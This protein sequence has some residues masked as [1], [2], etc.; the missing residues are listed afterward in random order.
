MIENHPMFPNRINV[1]FAKVLSP[2]LVEMLIWERGAGYTLASG[3]SSSAVASVM[4]KKG[5][6]RQDVTVK[7]PGGSLQLNIDDGWNIKM[8]GEVKE[9]ASGVL[10]DELVR[11]LNH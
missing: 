1:Q 7:M 8:T 5:L 10:S 4:V 11:E 9:I 3:S 2:S 6:T